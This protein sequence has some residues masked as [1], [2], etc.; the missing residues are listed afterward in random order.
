MNQ[1]EIESRLL[2]IEHTE[3]EW[4]RLKVMVDRWK[5]ALLT[6]FGLDYHD[7]SN[8]FFNEYLVEKWEVH[9]GDLIIRYKDGTQSNYAIL[10]ISLTST[11]YKAEHPD[12]KVPFIMMRVID[13]SSTEIW[14]LILNKDNEIV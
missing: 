5:I 9:H 3:A 14:A 8:V 2:L 4:L 11:A 6:D 12:D 1:K 13:P 10:D 7:Y